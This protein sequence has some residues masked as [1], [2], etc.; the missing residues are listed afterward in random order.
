MTSLHWRSLEV[1]RGLVHRVEGVWLDVRPL[2]LLIHNF[3]RLFNLHQVL[4]FSIMVRRSNMREGDVL[5]ANLIICGG[6][7]FLGHD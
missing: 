2:N 4:N 3:F 7:V 1:R 6:L 5:R